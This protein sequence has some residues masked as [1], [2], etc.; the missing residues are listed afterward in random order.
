MAVFRHPKRRIRKLIRD[1]E[2]SEAISYGLG[3]EQKYAGDHDFMFIM[4]SVFMLVDDAKKALPYFEKALKLDDRDVETMA[5]MTNAH[6]ALGQKEDAIA[7]CRRVTLLDPENGE[8]RDL[9]EQLE[10]M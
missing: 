2:Y 6:L 5:M 1:G 10:G 3:L 8:A 7:C 9:L 4:G